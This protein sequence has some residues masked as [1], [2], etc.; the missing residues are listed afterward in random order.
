MALTRAVTSAVDQFAARLAYITERIVTLERSSHRHNTPKSALQPVGSV[1]DFIGTTAPAGWVIM[2]GQTLTDAINVYPELWAIVPAQ[3][4]SG[5]NIILPDAR[6][7]VT[8]GRGSG[9]FSTLGATGGVEN[10]TLTAAQSGLR[11]HGH[12]LS[13]SVSNANV[14]VSVSGTTGGASGSTG[15]PSNNTTGARS[16]THTHFVDVGAG[17]DS[18]VVRRDAFN[19]GGTNFRVVNDTTNGDVQLA[20][21]EFTSGE[22]SGTTLH[23]H[24]MQNHTHSLN[25]HTHSFSGSGSASHGH[26]ASGAVANANAQNASQAHTNLQPYVV[27]TKILKVV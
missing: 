21:T 20:Y 10:V 24:D 1:Q 4:K 23:T 11:E 6:N 25:N 22:R 27:L 19:T 18:F 5:N 17:V 15:P 7:R 13:V 8:V 3:M 12:G 16:N 14:N 2:Q 9:T 26:S